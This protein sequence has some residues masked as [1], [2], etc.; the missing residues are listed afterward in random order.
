ME[1]T[2]YLE[3]MNVYN[4]QNQEA[5]RYSFDYQESTSVSGLPFFPN[6]GVRGA[7]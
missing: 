2:A 5:L 7:L 3:V 4:Q 6:L 1:L